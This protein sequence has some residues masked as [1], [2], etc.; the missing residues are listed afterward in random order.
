VF[1]GVTSYWE[2]AIHGAIVL[3]AVGIDAAAARRRMD[4]S[5]EIGL[6]RAAAS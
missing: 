5:R 1:L 2:R 6:R 4:R 3:M